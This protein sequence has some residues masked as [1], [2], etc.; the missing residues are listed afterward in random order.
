MQAQLLYRPLCNFFVAHPFVEVAVHAHAAPRQDH[1]DYPCTLVDRLITPHPR[2]Q[3]CMAITFGIISLFA[4]SV[5]RWAERARTTV[6]CALLSGPY[7][8]GRGTTSVSVHMRF[9]ADD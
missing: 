9:I 6:A 3:G 7:G 8:F 5:D 4:L 1:A 2:L